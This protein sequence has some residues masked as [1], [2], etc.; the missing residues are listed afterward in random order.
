[1]QILAILASAALL[2]TTASAAPAPSASTDMT[3]AKTFTPGFMSL[4]TCHCLA[5]CTV[6]GRCCPDYDAFSA[7]ASAFMRSKDMV[8]ARRGPNTEPA[9]DKPYHKSEPA[10]TAMTTKGTGK[11]AVALLTVRQCTFED[12]ARA[13]VNPGNGDMTTMPMPKWELRSCG[14]GYDVVAHKVGG[15]G[16]IVA[17]EDAVKVP[18][19]VRVAV[20]PLPPTEIATIQPYPAPWNVMYYAEVKGASAASAYKAALVQEPLVP[21]FTADLNKRASGKLGFDP[22]T[23]RKWSVR[24][25]TFGT[26]EPV[27]YAP[28]TQ[29]VTALQLDEEFVSRAHSANYHVTPTR[30]GYLRRVFDGQQWVDTVDARGNRVVAST[31]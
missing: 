28:T 3:C 14:E 24:A 18:A 15:N 9:K 23:G 25:A 12:V 17:F 19:T 11:E 31:L 27:K 6:T 29:D 16:Q 5:S 1:M 2:S 22:T 4:M 10:I 30:G 26:A 13:P 8:I 20:G 7:S 21:G